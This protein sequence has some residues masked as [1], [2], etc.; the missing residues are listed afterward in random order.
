MTTATLPPVDVDPA[1]PVRHR[2]RWVALVL[3]VLLLAGGLAVRAWSSEDKAD[4]RAGTTLVDADGLAAR[5]GI[6]VSLIA[7]T[8][9]GGLIEFRYQVVDPDKAD[10]VRHD[11]G[12]LPAMVVEDSGAT[13]VLRSPPHHHATETRLGGTYFVLF[14]NAANAIHGGSLVTVVIGDVRMEHIEAQA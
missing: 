14:P 1:E 4:I 3:A 7:V 6:E 8:A 9:A 11:D 10:P 12:L 13:L 2:R 5:Y